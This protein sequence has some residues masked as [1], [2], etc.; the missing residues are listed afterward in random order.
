[1]GTRLQVN[2][3][4]QRHKPLQDLRDRNT[5]LR[6]ALADHGIERD[7]GHELD[8]RLALL[9]N[10]LLDDDERLA[11]EIDFEHVLKLE[12]EGDLLTVSEKAS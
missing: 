12:M 10:R 11:L 5:A 8:V 6:L 9:I 2:P 4:D 7:T 1:M 3:R